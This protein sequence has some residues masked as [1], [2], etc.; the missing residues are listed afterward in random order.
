MNVCKSDTGD[1]RA[2][3]AAASREAQPRNALCHALTPKQSYV[4]MAMA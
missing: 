3:C 4:I 2:A 1:M